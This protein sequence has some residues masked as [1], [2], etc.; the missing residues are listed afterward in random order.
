MIRFGPS[1]IP[2]SCKGRTL[3]DGIM[4]VHKLGLTALEVQFLRTNLRSKPVNEEEIDLL[5][6]EV[7]DKFIVGVNRSPDDKDI[8]IED[9]DKTLRAGDMINYL[10]SGVAGEFYRMQKLGVVGNELD[11]FL[12]FHTPYYMKFTDNESEL[13]ERSKLAYKYSTVM[14]DEMNAEI[15]LTHLGLLEEGQKPEDAIDDVIENIREIRDWKSKT[16]DE[17][18]LI[19]IEVQAGNDV[20]GSF[21]DIVEVCKKVTG[22]V[23]VINFAHML[24]RG[25][26]DLEE[27]EEFA[28]VFE[29]CKRFVP[30]YHYVNFSGVEMYRDNYRMTPIKRGDLHFEPL[31]DNLINIDEDVIIISTSP[32]KEHDA[33][34][35]KVIFERIYT[36]EVAKEL[37]RKKKT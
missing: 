9:M 28:E 3:Y 32:L 18:P 22:T 5:A 4:D 35:M 34:Y 37:R 36:R 15:V 13:V 16:F 20:F 33:M 26:Y 29:E 6:R 12:S 31:V 2:L 25:E 1:G 10:T 27:P 11:V 21:D 14:A 30:G 7:E 19:G 8:Y 24:A 23:P 17:P